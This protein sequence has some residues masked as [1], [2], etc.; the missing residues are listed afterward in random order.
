M[1][2]INLWMRAFY[3]DSLKREDAIKQVE[4]RM[5][6]EMSDTL[7]KYSSYVV[8]NQ[9]GSITEIAVYSNQIYKLTCYRNK[10]GQMV[11]TINSHTYI[12]NKYENGRF[13]PTDFR[14]L[15]ETDFEFYEATSFYEYDSLSRIIKCTEKTFR[16]NDNGIKKGHRNSENF[17]IYKYNSSHPL[18]LPESE[19]VEGYS[20]EHHFYSIRK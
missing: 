12:Q 15:L 18:K 3:T 7:L 11:K 1:D 16:N 4:K 17:T 13:I 20:N 8:Y 5:K 2:S 6:E 10:N 14:K 9:D 19:Y